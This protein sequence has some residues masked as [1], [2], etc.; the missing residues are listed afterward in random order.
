MTFF[1]SDAK[2]EDVFYPVFITF[3]D[4]KFHKRTKKKKMQRTASCS[5]G[6]KE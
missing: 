2:R 6:A 3:Q 1:L 4:Q 5:E